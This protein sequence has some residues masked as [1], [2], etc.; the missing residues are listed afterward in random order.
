[1]VDAA[2]ASLAITPPTADLEL[3]A[4]QRYPVLNLSRALGLEQRSPVEGRTLTFGAIE[5]T[6]FWDTYDSVPPIYYAD[7]PV[8]LCQRAGKSDEWCSYARFLHVPPVPTNVTI[9]A[10]RLEPVIGATQVLTRTRTLTPALTLPLTLPLTRGPTPEPV[11]ATTPYP[12]TPTPTLSPIRSPS[13]GGHQV[14]VRA[15]VR[16]RNAGGTSPPVPSDVSLTLQG[17]MGSV[18]APRVASLTASDPDN[19][20]PGYSNGDPTPNLNPTPNPSPSPTHNPS[21]SPS[22]NPTPDRDRDPKPNPNQATCL[23]SASTSPSLCATDRGR[24]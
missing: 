22:P 8:E 3:G 14:R 20:G 11:P 2:G 7:S 24:R 12:Y 10:D 4:I 6:Y 21:P 13:P 15:A 1:V 5:R 16:L 9:T 19:S 18:A 23:R 17:S